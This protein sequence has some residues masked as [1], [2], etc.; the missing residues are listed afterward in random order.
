MIPDAAL[1]RPG[2]TEIGV[3]EIGFTGIRFTGIGVR[4]SD[5]PAIDAAR[6]T[7][8]SISSTVV[9]NEVTNR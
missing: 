2:F 3:T 8:W 1:G 7:N 9:E 5:G 4:H 6:S